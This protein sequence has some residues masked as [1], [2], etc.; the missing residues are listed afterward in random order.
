MAQQDQF[1]T[2]DLAP[3]EWVRSIEELES[4]PRHW[5]DGSWGNNAAPSWEL[6]DG[7][8]VFAEAFYYTVANVERVTDRY[9]SEPFVTVCLFDAVENVRGS[10]DV[11]AESF[12]RMAEAAITVAG[13]PGVALE[14]A[15]RTLRGTDPIVWHS[16]F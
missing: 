16:S 14:A 8:K 15:A 11:S 10:F 5:R 7:D 3:A 4:G 12:I 9:P 13:D 2:V 1:S 6:C